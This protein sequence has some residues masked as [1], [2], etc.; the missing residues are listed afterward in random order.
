MTVDPKELFTLL[1]CRRC[2]NFD[3]ILR[4]YSRIYQPC[5]ATHAP[6][7]MLYFG[8]GL[9]GADWSFA[10]IQWYARFTSLDLGF[11]HGP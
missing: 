2:G 5:A 6:Y 8:P 3:I 1:N 11:V 7:A 9:S 4:H 10:A